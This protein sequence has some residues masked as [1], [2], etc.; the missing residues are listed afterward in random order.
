MIK[1]A[2]LGPESSGKTTLAEMLTKKLI[3]TKYFIFA[4]KKVSL[5]KIIPVELSGQYP[6]GFFTK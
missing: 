4:L 5:E 6:L 2:F 3:Q 1:I